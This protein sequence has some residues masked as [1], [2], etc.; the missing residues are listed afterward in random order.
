MFTWTGGFT[1]QKLFEYECQL[2]PNLNE[3][4][5]TRQNFDPFNI[6]ENESSFIPRQLNLLID[7]EI[8]LTTT[9]PLL[10][11][12][13]GAVVYLSLKSSDCF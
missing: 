5:Q 13:Y 3:E 9:L 11:W 8:P 6:A 1:E 10:L 2:L 12:K 4:R 7:E